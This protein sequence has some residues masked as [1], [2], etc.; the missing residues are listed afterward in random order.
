MNKAGQA[1]PTEQ[2]AHAS[3][4][5]AAVTLFLA[6]PVS[7]IAQDRVFEIEAGLWEMTNALSIPAMGVD[8]RTTTTECLHG[9]QLRRSLDQIVA[10]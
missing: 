6:I 3:R 2:A 4:L 9:D 1:R 10:D 7:A 8:N 5:F